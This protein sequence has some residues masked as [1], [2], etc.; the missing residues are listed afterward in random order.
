[1][2]RNTMLSTLL[3]GGLVL[4]GTAAA[5]AA[6]PSSQELSDLTGAK[7]SMDQAISI[8]QK[9]T[10]GEAVRVAFADHHGQP[11]YRIRTLTKSGMDKVAIDATSGRVLSVA[12]ASPMASSGSSSTRFPL[13]LPEYAP[14]HD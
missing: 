4:G 10:G 11:I 8:A 5:F 2:K 14:D 9:T 6:S 12:S 1:M 13:N 3:A 7:T